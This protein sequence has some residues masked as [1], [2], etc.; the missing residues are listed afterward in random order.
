MA[1]STRPTPS[2]RFGSHYGPQ[3][4]GWNEFGDNS[5][6]SINEEDEVVDDEEF[7]W[8]LTKGM[9]LF[10]VSAKDDTGMVS[11]RL[12]LAKD[13]INVHSLRNQVS[14]RSSTT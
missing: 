3:A 10:E 2:S 4:G 1:S 7:E 12:S 11:P 6:N 5:S 9:E 14:K 8:G 13:P